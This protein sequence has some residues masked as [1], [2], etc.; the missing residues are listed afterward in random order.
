MSTGLVFIYSAVIRFGE[1]SLGKPH[2]S[3]PGLPFGFRVSGPS[4]QLGLGVL[5]SL[6]EIVD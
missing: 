5:L 2:V 1:L 4:Q 6:P 3:T